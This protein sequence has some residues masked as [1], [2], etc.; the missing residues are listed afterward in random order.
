MTLLLLKKYATKKLIHDMDKSE[1][2]TGIIGN[3]LFIYL[4]YKIKNF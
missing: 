1:R 2:R 4:N 3:I